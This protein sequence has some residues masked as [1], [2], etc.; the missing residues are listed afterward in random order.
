MA[1]GRVIALVNWASGICID[2]LAHSFDGTSA[3]GLFCLGRT[4]GLAVIAGLVETANVL[5]AGC[6]H[7]AGIIDSFC[8]RLE[9][10]G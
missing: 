9:L 6:E 7:I 2:S 4:Q 5:L 1:A 8:A 3:I 10:L